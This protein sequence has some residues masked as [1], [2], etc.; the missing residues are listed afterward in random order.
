[1]NNQSPT[2]EN[3]T[4]V[5]TTPSRCFTGAI[6]SGGMAFAMYKLVIAIATNF[7]NKPIHSDNPLVH[8]ISSIVRTA[9]VGVMMMGTGIFGIVSL[10]LLALGLQLLVQKITKKE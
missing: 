10:G 6:M 8:N 1:M 4:Q 7:A 5:P 2:T 9:V 3:K